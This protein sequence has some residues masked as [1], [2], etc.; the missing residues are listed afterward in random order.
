MMVAL[1]NPKII[2]SL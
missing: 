1:A 2:T